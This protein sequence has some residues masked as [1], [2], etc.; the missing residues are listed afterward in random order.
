MD[1]RTQADYKLQHID[2]QAIELKARMLRAEALRDGF[3]M[4]GR[5]VKAPFKSFQVNP[6]VAEQR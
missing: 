1:S 5:F 4:F 3:R 6:M 2:L